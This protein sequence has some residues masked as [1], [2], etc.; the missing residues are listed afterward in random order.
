M[1]GDPIAQ[2]GIVR[3][4]DGSLT[5]HH[6]EWIAFDYR[7]FGDL[8][9]VWSDLDVLI[10]E[11]GLSQDDLIAMISGRKAATRE[12]THFLCAIVPSNV[13]SWLVLRNHGYWAARITTEHVSAPAANLAAARQRRLASLAE[14][15]NKG[16]DDSTGVFLELVSEKV[17]EIAG[18]FSQIASTDQSMVNLARALGLS[19]A[20]FKGL[21]RIQSAD[22][23]EKAAELAAM[24]QLE[25]D[26]FD[27]CL[28]LATSAWSGV[29][30][31]RLDHNFPRM[32]RFLRHTQGS[33]Q[34]DFAT[35]LQLKDRLICQVEQAIGWPTNDFVT[36]VSG[37]VHLTDKESAILERAAAEYSAAL[38]I[39]VSR[40]LE[41]VVT[42]F[43]KYGLTAGGML[44]AAR[45]YPWLGTRKPE[46]LIGNIEGVVEY[47]PFKEAG[48][49]LKDY[50]QAAIRQPSLFARKPETMIGRIEGITEYGSFKHAGLLLKD[51]L[52]AAIKQPSLFALKPETVIGN[53]ERVVDYGP[54]KEAGLL[55]ED[56]LQAAVK[57]PQ[58]FALKPETVISR[59]E[60]VVE[61]GPFKE[62]GLLRKDYLQAGIKQPW[63][64]TQ[65]PGTVIG[66]IEGVVEYGP[67][68][69]V[70]LLLEDYLQAAIKQPQLLARKPETLTTNIEGV[71]RHFQD[72][73]LAFKDYLQAAI[74]QPSLFAR[75]PE[76]LIGHINRMIAMY[77]TGTVT[78]RKQSY[79]SNNAKPLKAFLDFLTRDPKLLCL[80]HDNFTLREIYAAVTEAK[81]SSNILFKPR[82]SIEQTL[83]EKYGH[84]DRNV[85]VPLANYAASI[86]EGSAEA[87]RVG[88]TLM[89]R[90][91][92]RG[93]L[94]N[95]SLEERKV[96]PIGA[97]EHTMAK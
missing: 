18:R 92:I 57:K 78:V 64:F 85:Q 75:K 88:N 33:N 3:N 2:A 37:L 52:Q 58:L 12:L 65:K 84:A 26:D 15:T 76:T 49:P 71:Y 14:Q 23:A 31:G 93:G 91:L 19:V 90:V 44:Q 46:T 73:G 42:H 28:E 5:D 83:F 86:K 30:A 8:L 55:V 35:A 21:S 4:D 6:I 39:D 38:G 74:R 9:A 63:L 97:Y 77:E 16:N 27:Q 7:N 13:C 72:H 66:H 50:L 10:R 48:L 69:E 53:I 24:L 34:R 59:I 80:S 20:E 62:A 1:P 68:K 45:R 43:S 94:L 70:G 87:S 47:G 36:R 56:Y 79:S 54:F 22:T 51:Y 29:S 67:F 60:G 41:R 32:V 95:G 11:L 61:Y 81:P 40:H 17:D 96:H 89:L 25:G 82:S